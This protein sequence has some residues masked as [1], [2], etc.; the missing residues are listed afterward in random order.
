MVSDISALLLNQGIMQAA[1]NTLPASVAPVQAINSSAAST[2]DSNVYAVEGDSLYNEDM[3]VNGDGVVT[4]EEMTQYYAKLASDYGG[5]IASLENKTA[6][7]VVTAAQAVNT[8]SANESAY[9]AP[10]TSLINISA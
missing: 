3:D 7:N 4:N 6:G 2:Q 10:Y 1:L 5:N 9:S 8:Y